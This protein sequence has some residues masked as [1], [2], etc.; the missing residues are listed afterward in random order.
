MIRFEGH[1]RLLTPP[2]HVLS[3]PKP[4]SCRARVR[5]GS[6]G[7]LKRGN[8]QHCFGLQRC[9]TVTVNGI[10]VAKSEFDIPAAPILLPKGPWKAVEG[11]VNAPKG[12]KA[13]GIHCEVHYTWNVLF[14]Q[15]HGSN[16]GMALYSLAHE[17]QVEQLQR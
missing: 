8:A 16:T 1:L 11:S 3:Q 9:S 10:A 14:T 13:Q 2:S 5:I 4:H 15:L 7:N 12:F 17:R 6:S